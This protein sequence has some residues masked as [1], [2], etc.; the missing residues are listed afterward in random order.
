MTFYHISQVTLSTS[1]Y[2]QVHDLGLK[3]GL[4]SSTYS[5]DNSIYKYLSSSTYTSILSKAHDLHLPLS[6]AHDLNLS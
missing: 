3:L 5:F 1:V 4:N 6:K 2:L